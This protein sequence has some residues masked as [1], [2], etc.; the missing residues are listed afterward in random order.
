M[1]GISVRLLRGDNVQ[2]WLYRAG[3]VKLLP[4]HRLSVDI[5]YIL[6]LREYCVLTESRI[7]LKPVL[8]SLYLSLVL[9]NRFH[10]I[11]SSVFNIYVL[12]FSERPVFPAYL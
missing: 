3:L 9:T 7:P 1:P 2:L 4:V 11:E 10:K 6:V 12:F 8:E 5:F